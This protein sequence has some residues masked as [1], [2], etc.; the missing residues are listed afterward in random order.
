MGLCLFFL[1]ELGP[2]QTVAWA[3]AYLHTIKLHLSPPSR[4]ATMD[5]GRKLEWGLCPFRGGGAG[6]PSNNVVRLRPTSVPCGILIQP[7]GHTSHEPKIGGC[8]PLFWEGELC[9]HILKSPGPRSTSLPRGILNHPAIWPQQIWAE[10][11]GLC[12]FGGGGAGSPSNNV[13]GPRLTCIIRLHAKFYLDP[14]NR[15]ATEQTD[16][17]DNGL[18]A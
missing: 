18:I 13:A 11:W 9:C 14:P 8:A 4:L 17:T 15:L 10:N 7:F 1:G 12:A 6:S 2:S 3:E 16:R 5:I